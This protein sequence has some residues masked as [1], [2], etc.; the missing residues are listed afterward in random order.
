MFDCSEDMSKQ[1]T[2]ERVTTKK[3]IPVI[4]RRQM[5][6]FCTM[7]ST[8]KAMLRMKSSCGVSFSMACKQKRNVNI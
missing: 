5:A 2:L 3:K 7:G 8:L 6:V 4:R 1:K